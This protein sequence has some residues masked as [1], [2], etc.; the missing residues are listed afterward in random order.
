M[1][2]VLSWLRANVWPVA[3]VVIGLFFFRLG[4]K[5]QLA[6]HQKEKIDEQKDIID[7]Q[8]KMAGANRHRVPD[9]ISQRLR[10]GDA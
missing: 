4:R 9:A 3:L 6:D 10:D 1:T 8:K 2:A 5:S 7:R